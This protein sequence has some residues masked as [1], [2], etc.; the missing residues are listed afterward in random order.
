M[1][2]AALGTLLPPL[3]PASAADPVPS[4]AA[5]LRVGVTPAL[6]PMVFKQGKELAG[7]DVELARLLG[8][9]LGRPVTFVEVPW[10][11]QIEALNQGRTDII[12]S[13][14]SITLPRRFIINFSDPY[15]TVGQLPLV[16]RTDKTKYDLGFPSQP[17]GTV[18]VLKSTTGDFLVQ[19]EFPKAKRKVYASAD[20][21]AKALIRRKSDLFISDS[22]LVWY[23]AGAYANEG[24]AVVPIPL[25][26]EELGW[27]VRKADAD[28]LAGVNRFLAKC[29]QDGS[30]NRV[31]QRWLPLSN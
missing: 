8:Q 19:R 7:I 15:L 13:A 5:P 21:A 25:S 22:T 20:E 9:N 6:P 10:E 23:L 31:I 28:L 18:G 17:P 26:Q 16:R 4:N 3:Q 24:L 11:D 14:M 27:G 29:R 2:S 12:M 1:A 30:L